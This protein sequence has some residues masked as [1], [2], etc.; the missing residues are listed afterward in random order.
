VTIILEVMNRVMKEQ[1]DRLQR[2]QR[3]LSPS[4]SFRSATLPS[5]DDTE[6]SD[7]TAPE[8]V[9]HFT[10]SHKLLQ[11]RL[12]P[13]TRVQGDLE[14]YLGSAALEPDQVPTTDNIAFPGSEAEPSRHHPE[15]TVSGNSPWKARF[16][17]RQDTKRSAEK[18]YA[19]DLHDAIEILYRCGPDIKQLWT[20]DVVQQVLK[21]VGTLLKHSSGLYVCDTP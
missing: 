20:D 11:L 16:L 6:L 8:A 21:E 14:R 12:Q 15:F 13:L 17:G 5:P 4:R 10:D 9:Y 19:H 2:Q 1:Q 3:S 7:E 18:K